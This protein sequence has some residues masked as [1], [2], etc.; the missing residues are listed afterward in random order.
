MSFLLFLRFLVDN[1][2]L[3]AETS[4][5]PMRHPFVKWF[6]VCSLLFGL[7]AR[8]LAQDPCEVSAKLHA[9]GKCH[10]EGHEC[11]PGDP[12]HDGQCPAEHHSHHGIC[13]HSTPYLVAEIAFVGLNLPCSTDLWLRH[14]GDEVPDGPCLEE[15]IP[16]II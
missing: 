6:L 5:Q 8:V 4:V 1:R 2:R 7:Y 10:V 13:G 11:P 16:P 9:D 12:D 15:D 14:E 3:R